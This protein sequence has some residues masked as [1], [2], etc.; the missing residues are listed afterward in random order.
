MSRSRRFHRGL[1]G[2][3]GCRKGNP[4]HPRNPR[5]ILL[6]V[7]ALPGCELC[8]LDRLRMLP[9]AHRRKRVIETHG[10][11]ANKEASGIRDFQAGWRAAHK[12]ICLIARER[13]DF[14]LEMSREV[15]TQ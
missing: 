8:R 10:D 15:E 7:E 2:S 9:L 1:R 11:V 12:A 14:A 4:R 13:L 6:L 3:R 5:L